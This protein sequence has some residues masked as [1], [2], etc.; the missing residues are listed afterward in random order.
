MA[1]LGHIKCPPEVFIQKELQSTIYAMCSPLHCPAAEGLTGLLR[2]VISPPCFL[3]FGPT[4]SA[5][6]DLNPTL[7]SPHQA[8]PGN[9]SPSRERGGVHVCLTLKLP[10]TVC[11]LCI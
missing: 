2:S 3:G 6:L 10:N 7:Q 8:A 11:I 4:A 1:K 9:D 5:S